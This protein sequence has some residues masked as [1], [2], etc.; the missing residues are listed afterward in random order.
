MWYS[1][2]PQCVTSSLVS[3][4]KRNTWFKCTFIQNFSELH[5]KS[6][7]GIVL[8]VTVPK[9]V[10]KKVTKP[11]FPQSI[12]Q[13]LLV[14]GNAVLDLLKGF[15]KLK[16]Y[17]S[18]IF[19]TKAFAFKDK[20]ICS[21]VLGAI[22]SFPSWMKVHIILSLKPLGGHK[23]HLFPAGKWDPTPPSM[24]VNTSICFPLCL[25]FAS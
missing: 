23:C 12:L 22:T 20:N 8:P 13:V 7:R 18:L 5:W 1:L 16:N 15:F 10:T 3:S 4:F 11:F 24:L 25:I 9:S 21:S 14:F 19:V 6:G 2:W 17:G